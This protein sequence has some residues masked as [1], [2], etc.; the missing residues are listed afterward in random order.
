[1]PARFEGGTDDF[2]GQKALRTALSR[3]VLSGIIPTAAPDAAS[4]RRYGR[5][6]TTLHCGKSEQLSGGFYKGRRADVVRDVSAAAWIENGGAETGS[7]K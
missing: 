7:S 4:G 5:L 1:M 3:R 2:Y 6:S